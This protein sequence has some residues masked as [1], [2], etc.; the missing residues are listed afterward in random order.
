MRKKIIII[1]LFVLV[2]IIVM[3]IALRKREY[4]IKVSI[5]DDRSP[6][7]MLKVYDNYNN[8]IEVKRIEYLDGTLLCKGYNTTV[9]FGDIVNEKK[10]VIILRDNTKAIAKVVEEEVK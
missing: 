7:R 5:I 8:E 10:L 6:D 4:I 1:S 2:T 9:F 3:L